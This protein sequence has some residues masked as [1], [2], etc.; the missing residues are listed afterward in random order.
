MPL[1]LPPCD[2]T[3]VVFSSYSGVEASIPL[4]TAIFVIFSIIFAASSIILL[5][6]VKGSTYTSKSGSLNLCYFH[7]LISGT[8]IL[9]VI[10]ILIIIFQMVLLNEYN[11]V[12]LN[13]Q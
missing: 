12:L 3:V 7:L 9:T 2:S 5:Y 11:L 4:N 13:I 6:S 8:V 1:L 10:V